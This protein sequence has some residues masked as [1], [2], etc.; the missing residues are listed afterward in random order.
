MSEPISVMDILK[1]LFRV[2]GRPQEEADEPA[3][4]LH[5]NTR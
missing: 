4:G 1:N 2:S 5:E 3:S